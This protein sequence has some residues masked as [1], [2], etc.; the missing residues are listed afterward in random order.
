MSPT[1]VSWSV[2]QSAVAICN[3]GEFEE[4]LRRN[5]ADALQDLEGFRGALVASGCL[6]QFGEFTVGK[7][8][9]D[10]FDSSSGA[11]STPPSSHPS[12]TPAASPSNTPSM[13][14]SISPSLSPAVSPSDTPSIH[15]SSSP[16][17]FPTMLPQCPPPRRRSPRGWQPFNTETREQG[18]DRRQRQERETREG[19]RGKRDHDE[20][21][22]R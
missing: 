2:E 19:T 22:K 8:T 4:D 5:L 11:P 14:P 6:K 12:I 17:L 16:S 7:I 20:R 21:S 15:P 18:R 13:S 3:V 9:L 1:D 10:A